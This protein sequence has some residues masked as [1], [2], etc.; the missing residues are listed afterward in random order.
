MVTL[1]ISLHF[2]IITY[3]S[4]RYFNDTE[5]KNSPKHKIEVKQNVF[6]LTI[7]KCDHPD[8]GIYRVHVDNGIDQTEQTATLHV[9]GKFLLLIY[10]PVYFYFALFKSNQKSKLQNQPMIKHVSL[11]KIHKSHGNSVASRNHMLLGSSM[12]NH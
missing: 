4:F 3:V 1:T 6:S 8:V 11:V 9:G 2:P 10:S 12:D 5:L 7:N